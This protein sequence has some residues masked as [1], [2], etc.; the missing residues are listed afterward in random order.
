[1]SGLLNFAFL[2]DIRI[3][4]ETIVDPS[5]DSSAVADDLIDS[6]LVLQKI[7]SDGVGTNI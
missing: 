5:A 1:M 6:N 2:Q 4:Q 7:T 3:I